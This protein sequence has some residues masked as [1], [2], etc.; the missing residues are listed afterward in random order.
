MGAE[1]AGQV[2]AHMAAM[3]SGV[4]SGELQ[5]RVTPRHYVRLVELCGTVFERKK[6][7]LQQQR[8]FLQVRAGGWALQAG[9]A[10]P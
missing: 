9:P 1:L 7:Q 6:V 8:G 2:A 5:P 4:A 3:H 10:C